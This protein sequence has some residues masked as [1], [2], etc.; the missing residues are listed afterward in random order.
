MS[1]LY[2]INKFS[3]FDVISSLFTWFIL[4]NICW[5]TN[6]ELEFRSNE[7]KPCWTR[8]RKRT[9]TFFYTQYNMNPFN[10]VFA[11]LYMRSLMISLIFYVDSVHSYQ[12]SSFCLCFFF[13]TSNCSVCSS[14]L[15]KSYKF[16]FLQCYFPI[17]IVLTILQDL[18]WVL[19]C[20]ITYYEQSPILTKH[21]M[22]DPVM[23]GPIVCILVIWF[24][25]KLHKVQLLVYKKE[26][27]VKT[28]D[29]RLQ[30]S[31]YYIN[32]L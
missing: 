3:F 15:D 4:L 10:L 30:T 9:W 24:H 23:F 29:F 17:W 14:A 12:K 26:K 5:R 8:Q 11:V 2:F 32:T 25:F 13:Y 20:N 1:R 16:K 7:S 21:S 22:I 28:K 27:N 6:S 19:S 18:F 31:H